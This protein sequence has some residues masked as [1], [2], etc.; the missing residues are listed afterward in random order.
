MVLF[1]GLEQ[2]L[3]QNKEKNNNILKIKQES[4][5]TGNLFE[6]LPREFKEYFDILKELNFDE[7][8]NYNKLRRIM[9]E[10]FLDNG[11]DYNFDWVASDLNSDKD[12]DEDFS[13]ESSLLNYK[14]QDSNTPTSKNSFS[15][16]E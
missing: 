14:N 10:L 13:K 15:L 16:G 2:K 1:L 3:N 11:F 7:T 8:P 5:R 9:K 12:M 6:N 4:L